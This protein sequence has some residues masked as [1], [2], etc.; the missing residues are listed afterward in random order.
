MNTNPENPGVSLTWGEKEKEKTYGQMGTGLT[1]LS[2]SNKMYDDLFKA[3][4]YTNLTYNKSSWQDFLSRLGFRT[5]YDRWLEDAQV[6]KAEYDAQIQSIIQQNEYNSPN[7]QA[8]RMRE[9]G[10]NPDLLGTQGVSDSASPTQDVNGM[11][12][13]AGDEFNQAFSQVQNFASGIMGM[14]QLGT[15]LAKD[16]MT[17]RQ[18]QQG[19][20]GQDVD[21]AKSFMNFANDYVLKSAPTEPFS[22]DRE[23]HDYLSK[24]GKELVMDIPKQLHLSRSQ[25][26]IW[27]QVVSPTY[28]NSEAF[29]NMTSNWLQ[30]RKNLD[31]TTKTKSYSVSKPII[32]QDNWNAFNIVADELG[33]L[34]NEVWKIEKKRFKAVGQRDISGAEIE[35]D[36]FD[37]QKAY[38]DQGTGMSYNQWKTASEAEGYKTDYYTRSVQKAMNHSIQRITAE[39]ETQ[40]NNGDLLS[41]GLLLA[42]NIFRLSNFKIF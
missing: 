31:E 7:A 20:A 42:M 4:P 29:K 13:N 10:M 15:G 23:Y 1:N 30:T 34:A 19:I 25:R 35:K 9:A 12:Q 3:N 22:N 2:H 24:V 16:F 33:D 28:F 40:A 11:M 14:F 26:K 32:G 39:L 18:M 37:T 38:K 17:F 41:A 36:L 21:L 6:N 27:G 8:D 5:D